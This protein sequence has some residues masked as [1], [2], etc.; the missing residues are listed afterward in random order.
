MDSKKIAYVFRGS[1]SSGKGTLVKKFIELLPGKVAKLELDVFRWAFH[2]NNRVPA[3]VSEAEHM[4][5]YKN[6]LLMLKSYCES[7]EYTL[8]LEG[9]FS[10]H[11][12]G[13][14]GNLDDVLPMLKK[15][16]YEYRAFLLTANYD[17]L[18]SRNKHRE[19]VVHEA[20][21]KDLYEY[22]NSDTSSEEIPIDVS[23]SI[24]ETMEK[25]KA[26]I[27]K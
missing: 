17:L 27:I 21:F 15:H 10:A 13:P 6:F 25:L 11:K 4:F 22:V 1:P 26:Y 23:G 3:D 2:L 12:S 18:W 8:V 9:L 7:G 24:E 19:Y 20:E 14:H 5:A 16:G